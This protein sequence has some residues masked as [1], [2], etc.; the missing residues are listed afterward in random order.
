[1]KLEGVR[2]E[3]AEQTTAGRMNVLRTGCADNSQVRLVSAGWAGRQIAR[4]SETRLELSVDATQK[5]FRAN[6]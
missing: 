3:E 2:L 4:Q 6:C 5:N 1:M